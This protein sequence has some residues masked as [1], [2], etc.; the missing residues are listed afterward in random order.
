MFELTQL[1]GFVAVAEELH[2]GRAAARLHMTQPPL[3]RQ[4]QLLEHAVGTLLLE[5][6]TRSV[7]LTI[8]GQAF[9]QDARAILRHADHAALKAVRIAH[10]AQGRVVFGHTA[11][12]AYALVPALL[13]ALSRSLPGMEIVLREMV[14]SSLIQGLADGTVEIAI[15]RPLPSAGDFGWHPAWREPLRIVLPK[16]HP[17]A[18]KA[19]V[20]LADLHQQPLIM[21]S[22]TEG[23]Y[24]HDKVASLFT[25]TG[26]QPR[27]VHHIAQTHT[28]L[29][30]VRAGIGLAIVPA[31]AAQLGLG[32][33][34][35]K[36]LWRKDVVAELFLAWD[37][38]SRN[39]AQ[40]S[41]REFCIG[42]LRSRRGGASMPG[43]LAV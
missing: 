9:L 7:R 31:S 24:L 8:A 14:S 3:S 41:V 5:R 29:S 42:H 33:V 12:A 19:R 6:S 23:R 2:F 32:N 18:A 11:G 21:Y 16:R 27:F 28:I 26:V 39:P 15:T 13:R 35:F 40:E 34:V 1:R 4:I 37:P 43:A 22:E 17:L 38:G 20:Q 36:S 30:L 10:G 25:A